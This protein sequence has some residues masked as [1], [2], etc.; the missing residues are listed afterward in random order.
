[1][2]QPT[3][4]ACEPWQTSEGWIWVGRQSSA[5]TESAIRDEMTFGPFTLSP[6][7]RR[8]T[9]DGV[10]VALSARSFDILSALI[11]RP[12]E[13]VGKR[14]LMAEVWPDATVSEDSLRFH[15]SNLR[16]ALGDG[17]DGM[18]YIA[19]LPGRGYC[20]V[21]PATR[22]A[23][24]RVLQGN[25]PVR[26]SLIG[27]DDELSEVADFLSQAR[28]VTI[29]GAG[30]LGKT[31]LAIAAGWKSAEVYPDGVWLVDLA[32]LTDPSLIVST[33]ATTLGLVGGPAA[34]SADAIV[35]A[36]AD[37]R[38]LL[39]LDNCEHL[40]GATADL[41]ATLLA[42]I[43]D[44]TVL[45]TSQESLRLD[46]EQV[47][48]LRPLALPPPD[49]DDIAGYGA[50][51]LFVHRAK[52]ADHRFSLTEA[53]AG[54]VAE[55]CRRLDGLPLSLEMAAARA[56]SLGLDGLRASLD[57]RLQMLSAGVRT[58]D[59]RHQTLRG[60]VAWSVGLL[61]ETDQRVF[62]RLSI[63]AGGFTLEAAMAVVGVDGL[64][65]WAVADAVG[66]LVDKS[67]V[68]FEASAP[69]RYRL[70][71]TLR[72]YAAELLDDHDEREELRESH[73]RH[74]CEVFRPAFVSWETVRHGQSPYLPELDNLRAALE[75]AAHDPARRDIA[76][77]L[78]ASASSL[79]REWGVEH[80]GGRFVLRAEDLLDD[81][82]PPKLA[83]AVRLSAGVMILRAGRDQDV[84]EV[85][86]RFLSVLEIARHIGDARLEI[87]AL[88]NLALLRF[89]RGDVEGAIEL[90]WESVPA[91]GR[92]PDQYLARASDNLAAY[93]IAADRARE[94]RP[95]A[96][97]ALDHF[98][99]GTLDVM[100][101]LQKWALIAAL[102]GRHQEAARLIGWVNARYAGT[103][104]ERNV[105]EQ[106]SYE[107]LLFLFKSRLTEGELS[108]LA[109]E[110]GSWDEA[111]AIDFTIKRIVSVEQ[112]IA[113]SPSP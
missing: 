18:R 45:A 59:V 97:Q 7:E 61:D 33:I 38:L 57:A 8:L 85:E 53:T 24:A 90:G 13:P 102:E 34:I 48:R 21:A 111:R 10:V 2:S 19:T 87:R 37:R 76:I 31:R 88:V 47:Y 99:P 14:Q 70:L 93:L 67:L 84:A 1:V 103:N 63:F 108:E 52:A 80:E 55:I 49:A 82:T 92:V 86:R 44:L 9:R 16:K 64:R 66:R 104:R 42:G 23:V 41:T 25:L 62:R 28:L 4:A 96:K 27:R 30:G 98:K 79:W 26:P 110:G 73:A 72:L 107:R 46:A 112:P 83:A 75:W 36:L 58:Q 51:E 106:R 54:N 78:A 22:A 20:F 91:P 74:F 113:T 6:S 95:V 65:Q 100:Q 50:V 15:M 56:M 32:P 101:N 40:I 71:E 77:E 39:I 5:V 3:S 89:A 43:P 17:R 94:A 29:V 68:T 81:S 35:A 11:A 105:W 60:T 109:A 69:K 12:S